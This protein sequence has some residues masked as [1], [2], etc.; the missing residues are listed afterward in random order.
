[1]WSRAQSRSILF[2]F[3]SGRIIPLQ[4]FYW[5]DT[6]LEILRA[7]LDLLTELKCGDNVERFIVCVCCYIE[8]SEC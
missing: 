3:D 6:F 2:S 1:M 4:L 5:L 7:I 8:P